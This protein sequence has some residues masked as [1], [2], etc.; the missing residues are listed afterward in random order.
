MA[1]GQLD[2]STDTSAHATYARAIHGSRRQRSPCRR[3][4]GTHI[5]I[6]AAARTIDVLVDAAELERRR[7]AWKA[8]ALKR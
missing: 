6:D 2:H 3:M 7:A 8:P 5:A 4:R 1:P